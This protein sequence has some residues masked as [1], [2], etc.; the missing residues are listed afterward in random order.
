MKNEQMKLWET[1]KSRYIPTNCTDEN[2]AC[3]RG[4]T[5]EHMKLVSE[6]E[7]HEWQRGLK[8]R[9]E[10][11]DLPKVNRY[12]FIQD[13]VIRDIVER[14]ALGI[15]RYG[16]ALQPFNGRDAL[17]D[18]YEEAIDLCMY[19]KQIIVERDEYHEANKEIGT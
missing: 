18:A 6:E 13:Q 10:D 15:R 17:R 2:C 1:I 4:A 11:Q 9:R 19:L 8:K 3:K 7:Y 12:L 14:K 5:V 16:T